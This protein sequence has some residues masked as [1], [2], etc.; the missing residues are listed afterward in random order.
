[1]K[2][3]PETL[4]NDPVALLRWYADAGVDEAIGDEPLDR[5]K[6]GAVTAPSKSPRPSA[7]VST[8]FT[9]DYSAASLGAPLGG[10]GSSQSAI[11]LAQAA[12]TVAALKV[13]VEA[14]EGCG[15]K[16][17]SSSTVF[18]DGNPEARIMFIGE[19]PGADEDRQGRPF[20]G[21][22]G[23]LL[24]KM[25][26]SVDLDRATNAYI[27]NIVFWRPPGNRSPTDQE[28]SS[29]LPFV[30][31]HVE[32]I[33]P[34]VLVFVGG[35]AAKT[36]LAKP[37]GITKLRG[38]WYEYETPGMLRPVPCMA[39]FPPAYLL[40]SPQQKR[41][42]WRDLLTIKQKLDGTPAV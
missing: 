41:L 7:A 4:T 33:D 11:H 8:P 38:R 29:C 12:T 39:L 28:I 37:M 34:A 27:T 10:D 25:L 19:A 17:F 14:F 18:A 15:L 3:A 6:A 24:D 26:K 36:L 32:L 21:V 9:H 31:R 13:A 42:A 5:F 23:Q 2:N 1:M 16:K 20:V 35:M 40:R 22:S 30:Q